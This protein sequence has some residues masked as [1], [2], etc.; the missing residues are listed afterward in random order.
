[1]L[2][3]REDT[4]IPK[5]VPG[6]TVSVFILL[7]L[8]F[9]AL[10]RMPT[11]ISSTEA[12]EDW[13]NFLNRAGYAKERFVIER[14]ED[15]I[16]ALV[17]MEDLEMLEEIS[18]R[19]AAAEA[20]K[21]LAMRE[22]VP[23]ARPVDTGENDSG[24]SRGGDPSASDIKSYIQRIF[25]LIDTI[26]QNKKDVASQIIDAVIQES[27]HDIDEITRHDPSHRQIEKAAP[28]DAT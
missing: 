10:R 9:L 12:R 22:Q 25:K 16:A 3:N 19:A 8:S 2:R 4:C 26:D 17:S 20:R 24:E 6:F 7:S 11:P 27:G 18:N 14:H 13:A 23:S 21:A 1:M 28:F 5:E 15:P